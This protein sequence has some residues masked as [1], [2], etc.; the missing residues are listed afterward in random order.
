ME[1]SPGE[2]EKKCPKIE[3][4]GLKVNAGKNKNPDA[5]QTP[6]FKGG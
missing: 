4:M 1:I 3:K 2:H 6:G 5:H